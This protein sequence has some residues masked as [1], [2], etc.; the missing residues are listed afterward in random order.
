MNNTRVPRPIG[1]TEISR[2]YNMTNDNEHYIEL[3]QRLIHHYIRNNFS[4]CG[5]YYNIEEFAKLTG[6]KEPD[7]MRH[8]GTYGK[9]LQEVHK[10]LTQGDMVRALTNLSFSWAMEDKSLISQQIAILQSSQGA[11]YVPFIS[12]ELNKA[13][14]LGMDANNNIMGLL[15]TITSGTGALAPYEEQG[16]S[17][18]KGITADEAVR[19]FKAHDV[20][21]LQKDQLQLDRLSQEY[22]IPEM[23][24]V[25]ALLQTNLDTSKEGLSLMSLTDIDPDRIIGH[26]NRREEEFEIDPDQDQI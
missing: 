15:K 20:T 23:P 18:E 14:K 24:I 16:Q 25:N 12:G 6:V 8:M 22:N 19:L 21:P 2:L 4:Y 13:I 17:N 9:Q 26:S 7:I 10:E 3:H 1:I 5:I 11:T